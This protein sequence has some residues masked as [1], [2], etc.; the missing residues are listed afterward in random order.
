MNEKP[1]ARHEVWYQVASD[2]D[3]WEGDG[4][5]LI[6]TAALRERESYFEVTCVA[7]YARAEALGGP[8]VT[9]QR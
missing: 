7:S 6:N 3:L 9:Q 5:L 1:V 4:G 2:P 8:G